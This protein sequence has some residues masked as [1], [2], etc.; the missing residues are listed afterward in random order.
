MQRGFQS[1]PAKRGKR[2]WSWTPRCRDPPDI[3]MYAGPPVPF[4]TRAS[5]KSI[6]AALAKTT[7]TLA[8]DIVQPG[9]QA[10]AWSDFEW[11]VAKAVAA[12]HG[13]SSLLDR[14]LAWRGPDHWHEFLAG[15]RRHTALR[16]HRIGDLLAQID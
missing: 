2:S 8:R 3:D 14:R 6:R 7:E 10:P 16:H 13:I 11:R 4:S 12:L 15:Q 5:L 1:V 9:T